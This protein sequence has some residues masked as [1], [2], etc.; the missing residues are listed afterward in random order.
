MVLENKVPAAFADSG[1]SSN[2]GMEYD[3]TCGR[4][5]HHAVPFIDMGIKPNK[6]FRYAG[7]NLGVASDVKR[8]PL[9]VRESASDSRT[10]PG[11]KNNLL[12]T[13]KFVDAG[14]TWLFDNDEVQV[15]D[16]TNTKITTPRVAVLKGWRVPGEK[17]WRIPLVGP[18]GDG[19]TEALFSKSP[20]KILAT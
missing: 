17:L 10:V 14:Y 1:A 3:S 2:C 16:K 20:T 7:G 6:M 15:F 8:L 13:G 4:Y 18:C 9:D 5:G 11:I 12:S 19:G